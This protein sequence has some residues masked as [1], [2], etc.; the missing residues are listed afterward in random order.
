MDVLA[1]VTGGVRLNFADT[2]IGSN[3][4]VILIGLG[5]DDSLT[6]GAGVDV[7]EGGDGS[8]S[9]DGAQ[10]RSTPLRTHRA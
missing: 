6:G 3:V 9:I 7:L 8:D 2:L 5:G 1:G 10:V 4:G